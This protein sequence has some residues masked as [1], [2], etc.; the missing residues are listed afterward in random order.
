MHSSTER[1]P[2]LAFGLCLSSNT[3][4]WFCPFLALASD[5]LLLSSDDCIWNFLFGL[6]WASRLVMHDINE[7]K[8]LLTLR[9]CFCFPHKH[10]ASTAGVSL[11]EHTLLTEFFDCYIWAKQMYVCAWSCNSRIQCFVDP[12][13][14][15]RILFF[16]TGSKFEFSLGPRLLHIYIPD[17]LLCQ[18]CLYYTSGR[19]AKFLQMSF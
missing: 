1:K 4:P 11:L 19:P 10:I 9:V 16:C 8:L 18:S 7:Y 17:V 15:Y 13:A 14:D 2:L 6:V 3:M 5:F 12:S